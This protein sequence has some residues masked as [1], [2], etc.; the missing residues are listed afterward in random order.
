MPSSSLIRAISSS[1]TSASPVDATR[2]GVQYHS[3]TAS[4]WARVR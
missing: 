2:S 4:A 3:L 1:G